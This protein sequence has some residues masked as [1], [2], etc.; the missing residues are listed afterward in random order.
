MSTFT[1]TPNL[2]YSHNTCPSESFYHK[3]TC[4]QIM[5]HT[6]SAF[7]EDVRRMLNEWNVPGLGIAV[8]QDGHIQAKVRAAHQDHRYYTDVGH[9]PTVLLI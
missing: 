3:E 9:R 1:G 8:V 2:I 7:D 4:F 5:A 6:D